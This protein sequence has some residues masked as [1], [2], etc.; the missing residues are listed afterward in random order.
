VTASKGPMGAVQ[1]TRESAERIANVVR[2]A[3]TTP[4]AARPL[5][6]D[7]V[8]QD[9]IPK[10]VRAAKFSGSWPV[11]SSKVVTFSHAPTATASVTNLSW[12]IT[13]SAYSNENCLVGREGTSWWL[14]VPVLQ[15]ATAVFVTQTASAVFATQTVTG[16]VISS[17]ASQSVITGVTPTVGTISCLSDVSVSASLNTADCTISVSVSKTSASHS[18]VTGVSTTGGT[19]QVVNTT[20]SA[21]LISG[22]SSGAYVANSTTAAYLRIRVP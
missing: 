7:A 5:V 11:G 4:P 13:A 20:A 21:V 9:R 22:A 18:V 8:M 1:F 10:Q 14:V 19:V 15:T 17:M 6:F 2:V 16:T 3:E 12:P